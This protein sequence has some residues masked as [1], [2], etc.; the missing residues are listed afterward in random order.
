MK[1]SEF[2]GLDLENQVRKLDEVVSYLA[3]YFYT[4]SV[5]KLEDGRIKFTNKCEDCRRQTK[6][7]SEDI[8]ILDYI[9]KYVGF[10]T[11]KDKLAMIDD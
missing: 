4:S 3:G 7:F 11:F 8:Q 6:Y 2:F 10:G 5:E 1:L 9:G